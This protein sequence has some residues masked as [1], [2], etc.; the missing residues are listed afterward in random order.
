[1]QTRLVS[2][3]YRVPACDTSLA[4]LPVVMGS[5]PDAGIRLNE[6]TV[7]RRHCRIE[8]IDGKLSVRD[9][10]SVHGTFVNGARIDESSLMPGDVLSVG[11][12]SFFLQCAEMTRPPL[13]PV[14]RRPNYN[15]SRHG[16]AR[17][18]GAL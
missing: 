10:G 12:L 3:D 11:V 13:E 15:T 8:E 16:D 5:G 1:M 4:G 7:S 18:V 17:L 14:E 2:L 9:L 6:H